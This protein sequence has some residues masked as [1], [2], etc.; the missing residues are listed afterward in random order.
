MPLPF[1]G[2]GAI[3]NTYCNSISVH[4]WGFTAIVKSAALKLAVKTQNDDGFH[5]YQSL[6]QQIY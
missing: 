1:P 4:A 5:F 3:A 6:Q 2:K